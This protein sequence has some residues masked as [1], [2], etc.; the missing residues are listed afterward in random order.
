MNRLGLYM[1]RTGDWWDISGVS[2]CM[3]ILELEPRIVFQQVSVLHVCMRWYRD[4]G[5]IRICG[6]RC[7]LCISIKAIAAVFLFSRLFIKS[8]V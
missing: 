3:R 1:R 5:G 7:E 8:I 2:S 4:G 6:F